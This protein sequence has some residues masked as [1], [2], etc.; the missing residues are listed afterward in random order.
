MISSSIAQI[1]KELQTLSPQQLIEVCISVAKFKKENKE[2]VDYLL[3]KA[4]NED[5][6]IKEINAEVS[7]LMQ[8]VHYTNIYLAKKSIRKI[9][10]TVN[11][12]LHFSKNSTT[13]VE[14]M[15]HFC[16]EMDRHKLNRKSEPT[17]YN[18]YQN[19]LKKIRKEISKMHEDLQFDYEQTLISLE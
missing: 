14:I 2:L 13:K 18:I 5:D 19:Q 15:L 11:K 4:E 16:R 1:K 3:F 12:Y 7:I 10:K 8:E 17:L 9:L 6:F